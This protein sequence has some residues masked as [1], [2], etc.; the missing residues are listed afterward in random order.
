VITSLFTF[1]VLLPAVWAMHLKCKKL[2]RA[3]TTTK[4]DKKFLATFDLLN[5]AIAVVA[6]FLTIPLLCYLI[7]AA[8][9]AMTGGL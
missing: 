9:N 6:L 1:F 7:A 5:N 2:T 8:Y 4:N 3:L